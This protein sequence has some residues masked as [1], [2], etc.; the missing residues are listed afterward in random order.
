MDL[1]DLGKLG[2]LAKQMQDAYEGGVDA[3]SQAGE[4]VSEST[5]PDHEVRLDIEISAQVE[6]HPYHV[7][8]TVFFTIELNTI[9]EAAQS[10]MGNL[11]ELLDGLGVDLGEDKNAVMAQLGQPRAV[12]IVKEIN[13]RDL[14]L[15]D[16]SGRLETSLNAKGTLLAII[17]DEGIAFNCE[18]VFSYPE[19]PGCH[20]AIPSM[21]A[22]QKN[23]V[24]PLSALH[25]E[26]AFHWKEADKDNLIVKGTLQ[27]KPL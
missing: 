6:N 16:D 3:M 13:L 27:I 19:T 11:S 26:A 7:D 9:L 18:G 22:M 2:D 25:E 8:G 14:T 5:N 24:V 1:S 17:S 10:P 23:I 15:Y 12:G 4:I 20:A 21:E